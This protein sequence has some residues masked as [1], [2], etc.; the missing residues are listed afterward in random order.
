MNGNQCGNRCLVCGGTANVYRTNDCNYKFIECDTC[1]RFNLN[2]YNPTNLTALP[3]MDKL[4]SYLYYNG[5]INQ[6]IKTEP[7]YFFNFIGSEEKFEKEYKEYP[8][9]YHVTKDI[10]ENWYPKTFSEKV[11][12]FLLGLSY[13]MHFV[14]DIISLTQ[15]QMYSAC[16]VIRN[17]DEAIMKRQ[18][19]YFLEYLTS[20]SYIDTGSAG[21][22]VLPKGLKR[23]DELQK[24]AAHDSKTAFIAMSFA[25]DM[26]AVRT[27]IKEAIS[28]AGF[29]PRVMDEIEHNHQI[30]PE[31]LHEIRQAK[32]VVAELTNHN[33]GAYFEAG[34][35]LGLGKDVIQVCKKDSF[36]QDGHFDVKQVNTV[37][38]ESVDD[39]KSAL[40]NR[41][42]ATI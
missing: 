20:E 7:G 18:V 3:D 26:K 22:M 5:K 32:F 16:F 13:N 4:A 10:V 17:D 37:L 39:L 9:C 30:V 25:D 19:C 15:D 42:K 23:I 35:A 41:I 11:D 27:A 12:M 14:G 28:D 36:G 1:G 21:I 33:N 8:Y 24:N 29:V 34:Y 38:W 6:P 40:L 2:T 31:M